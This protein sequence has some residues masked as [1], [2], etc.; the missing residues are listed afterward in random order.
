MS[1]FIGLIRNENM[2]IY[3]RIG[4]LIMLAMLIGFLGLTGILTKTEKST[5]V[6]DN[7]KQELQTESAAM[8]KSMK[9]EPMMKSY[10]ERSIALNEYRISH[11]MKPLERKDQWSFIG[12]STNAVQFILIFTIIVAGGTV[13]SEFSW[14]TIKL[15]LIRPVSRTTIL[16]SKYVS[17]LLYALLMLIITFVSAWLIGGVFFGFDG[18]PQSYLSYVDGKVVEENMVWHMWKEY[19]FLSVTL[20]LMTT[21]AF[22]LSTVFR[23]SSLA[24]GFSIFLSLS[25]GLIVQFLSKYEWV[26]YVLFANVDLK[27]YIDGTPLVKGMTMNFS[28]GVLAVYFIIFVGLSLVVFNKRDVAA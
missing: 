14:G 24:I 4:N 3:R 28:L 19:G 23:N 8:K 12:D 5:P 1:N 21:F 20:L 2:K 9:E 16:A 6:K 25:G 13:A 7:W 10:Y 22:M 18:S 26:K 15:L 27:Q 17:T 11:D